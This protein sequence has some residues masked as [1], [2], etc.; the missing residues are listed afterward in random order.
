MYNKGF[1]LQNALKAEN[2]KF[3]ISKRFLD[4]N[5]QPMEWELKNLSRLEN[6][7]I[8]N[9]CLKRTVRG[10]ELDNFKYIG[11]VLANSVIYPDLNSIELQDS[12]GVR[13]NQEVLRAML[14]AKEFYSL[15][16]KISFLG[17]DKKDLLVK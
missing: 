5:G 13:S 12:Y 17:S 9:S 2:E 14:T 10:I 7:E 8:L 4:E 15:Q 16:S 6:E 1:M 3:V 11:T